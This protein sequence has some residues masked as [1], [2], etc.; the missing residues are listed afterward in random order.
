MAKQGKQ[1]IMLL[2]ALAALIVV[3]SL[4]G[5]KKDPAEGRQSAPESNAPTQTSK[6]NAEP[7]RQQATQSPGQQSAQPTRTQT[8]ES[9]ARKLTLATIVKYAR[10]WRPAFTTWS[11]KKAPDFAII[12][13]TGKQHK[14]IDYRGKNV[15]LIF[16][17]PWCRPCIMEIP[18]LIELRNTVSEDKLAM[19]GIS[20]LTAMPPNSAET[21]KK[22]IGRNKQIN[23]TIFAVDSTDMPTPYNLVNSIPCSF[24]IDPNGNVK[25][26]TEGL[27]SLPEVKAI[28]EAER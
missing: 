2:A 28:I 23:Y 13:I 5:C 18:Y 20:F 10:T 4:A 8:T 9:D 16:W 17:A 19:L 27:I 7:N 25:I 11:G 26:V 22:F 24:F 21:V 6:P 1:V 12:D 3:I 14:L 15:M